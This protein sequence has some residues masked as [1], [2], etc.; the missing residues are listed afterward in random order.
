LEKSAIAL[1][2]MV[3]DLYRR[4]GFQEMHVIAHSMGG[5]VARSFILH[6]YYQSHQT[7]IK[8]FI[9]ISSPWNGHKLTAKG[10]EQA[11]E[12][13]PSWHDMVPDSAFIQALFKQ[14]LPP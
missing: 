5:L 13:I 1:D 7:F 6:N 10:V 4:Y 9:S 14:D 3:M 12:A 11:P 2:L 8:D